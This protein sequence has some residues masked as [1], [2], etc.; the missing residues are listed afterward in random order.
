MLRNQNQEFRRAVVQFVMGG[1][2]LAVLTFVGLRLKLDLATT[3]FLYLIVIV[4]LSLQGRFLV[5]AILSFIAV[6]CLA[7][8]FA[9]PDFSF[10][11]DDL[12]GEALAIVA[13]LISSAVITRLVSRA[14]NSAEAL[15]EQASLLNLTHDTIFVRDMHDV[16][17]FWN[18]GAEELYGWTAGQ[19]VGKTTTHQLLQTVFPAPIEKINAELLRTG[20]WEGELMHTKADGTRVRVASR[21]SL[22]RDKRQHPLAVLETNNDIT[23]RKRAEAKLLRNEAYLSEAQRLSHTGSFG[24]RVST[25]EILWSEETFR[26]FQYD[27]TTKPSVELITQRVHPE[28]VAFVKQTIERALQ[29]G[30]DFDFQHRL[31]M[32]DGSVKCVQV[33]AHAVSDESGSV[34]FIGAVMDV[35]ER[36]RAELL[37]AGEKRLLEMIARGDSRTLILDALCRFVEELASGALSSVL[38]LDPKANRL[39]HGAAPSLPAPY[40]EAIDGIVIGSC[41]GSCGT[42][43][44]RGEP[45]IVTDIAIDPLWADF[46][47]LALAHGLRACWSTP[48][49][50]SAG[51]VLGTFAIYYREPRSP[52]SQEQNLIE[53]ITH[54]AS[55]AVE[56]EQAEEALRQAQANLAHVSR[57]TTMG[58]LTASIAHEVGQPLTGVVNNANA[59]LGLLPE[60]APN[61]E[62]VREALTEII[63]DAERASAIIARVRQL[64]KKA[65]FERTRLD[66]RELITDVLA[67]ARYE[68]AT[69]Q[70]TIH[71]EAAEDLPLVLGDR[72]QLQ[73]VLLNLIVNGMDAMNTVEQSKRVLI[74]RGHRETRNGISAVLLSVKD[75][76]TGF[77][78]E[79][80]TRLFEAFYTTKPEGMGMGLAISRSI[81][82][83]HGGRLWAEPNQG[84]GATFLFSLPDAGNAAS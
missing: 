23:E 15:R 6:G 32:P 53:Q 28:D 56:R 20:R 51:R 29:D 63:D 2:A 44:Y 68:S 69:R 61:L 13:F 18:R 12:R 55:I 77:K 4:L 59:C 62:E 11:V 58:E 82:E 49:I 8:Y 84:P 38:L 36:K 67:L 37:L 40:T 5:S 76:G 17:T 70:I 65:P 19:V 34:E 83:T 35:T 10:R 24:W 1:I 30:N 81:I 71:A 41:V 42:A 26:I 45:V 74:L 14:R 73:Q 25:G 9:P 48:I 27:R 16:I 78:P 64:A 72:V 7:Y 47:D 54:L 50:S 31:L 80:M 3:A 79:E 52:T 39:R 43:A 46:C 33:V 60:S 21:W 22:Q 66:V 57:V 75:A